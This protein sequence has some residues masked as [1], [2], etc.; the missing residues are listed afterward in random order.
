MEKRKFRFNLI[1]A[2]IILIIL[3]A[4]ALL[5]YVFL[6]SNKVVEKYETH[7]VECVVEITRI[8]ELFRDKLAEGDSVI[9]YSNNRTIGKVTAPPERRPAT[10][11]AFDE[12]TGE[13]VYPEVPGADDYIVTFVGTAEKTEWGY[14]FADQYITVNDTFG[15]QIGDIQC[16]CTCIKMTVLD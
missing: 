4:A 9:N 11:T 15:L 1:D 10:T 12:S 13:E 6:F 2:F 16:N 7:E 8:N 3:A 5:V 14:R